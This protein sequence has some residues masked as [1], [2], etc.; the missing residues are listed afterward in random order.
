[1]GVKDLFFVSV[2]LAGTATLGAGLFR[3]ASP[4]A[5][6]PAKPPETKTHSE[7]E[8]VVSRVNEA[9]RSGWV[10]AKVASAPK[11]PELAV[12]RR[13]SLALM[14]AVP[15]LEEIRRF[16]KRPEGTRVDAWID[17]LLRDRR[18]ADYLAERMARAFVGTEDGPFVLFRR[19]RFAAWLSDA[20]LANRPYDAIVKDMIAD[21]GLWTDHP[22]TNFVSVTFN[23]D[24]GKPDP[25]RLAARV[26]RA[27]LGVR[28][29]C[30]QCHDHPF[31]PWKQGDFRNLAAFFGEVRSDLRG[32]GDGEDRYKPL[33]RKTKSPVDV[34][35]KV[36]SLPELCPTSGTARERLAAWVVDP[37]NPSL[38]RATANRMWALLLG[39]ALVQP[40]DDLPLDAPLPP[41][42]SVLADDFSSHGFDLH[43]LIRVIA[44]T[45]AFRLDSLGVS[46]NDGPTDAQDEAWAAFPMT[47]LRPEQVAGAIYQSATLSTL[48]PESSWVTR[49]FAYTS[50][51]DFVHRYGDT[52]QDEFDA[53]SGT[54]PQ[55][56]LLM[57]GELVEKCIKE[58]PLTASTQIATLAP[59]DRK[60]VEVAYLAVLTRRPSPEESAHFEGRL[61]GTTGD[62]RK[63]RLT[64]LYWTLLNATEFSWNH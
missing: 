50:R 59:D 64:D 58:G 37:R 35:P 60:A 48:G 30:A 18:T 28:I 63:D 57:N 11:A 15:S 47:R 17:D 13:L 42:L 24:E 19:R 53:R 56:L 46:T 34:V 33:D 39:R 54:I 25:E 21:K 40:V 5:T 20:V 16:E 41:A 27:F 12:M 8:P 49:F 26:S 29:D 52:G 7:I 1:M 31:Q 51:N 61:R 38:S 23:P 14:G 10:E 43:R 55:R 2:V 22:A 62:E 3:P 6:R 44:S 32:I 45:E 36:P 4:S 9:I